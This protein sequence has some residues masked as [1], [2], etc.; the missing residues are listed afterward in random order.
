MNAFFILFCKR[1]NDIYIFR[2]ETYIL[3]K[4]IIH[5]KF[6]LL[7]NAGGIGNKF[8]IYTRKYVRK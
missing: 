1:S 7:A 3:Y 5:V 6:S 8:K 4:K 2:S